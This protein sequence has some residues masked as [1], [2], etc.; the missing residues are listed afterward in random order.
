MV[1]Y[2]SKLLNNI[3]N[4]NMTHL[5]FAVGFNGMMKKKDECCV[6]DVCALTQHVFHQRRG[7]FLQKRDVRVEI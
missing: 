3:E 2:F 5:I 6:W 1:R 7:S 4:R